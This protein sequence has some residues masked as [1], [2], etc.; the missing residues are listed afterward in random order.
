MA[1]SYTGAQ[2]LSG[3]GSSM[4]MG[5]GY[6]GMGTSTGTSANLGTGFGHGSSEQWFGGQSANIY[7]EH[8]RLREHTPPGSHPHTPRASRRIPTQ[9]AGSRERSRD[10]SPRNRFDD[11]QPLPKE[12]GGRMLVMER[13]SREHAMSI[14]SIS[15]TMTS[16]VHKIEQLET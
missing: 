8:G 2:S 16:L 6:M 3:V 5:V 12:W 1:T 15:T 13:V 9:R 10:R 11:G 14:A 4:G 7:D